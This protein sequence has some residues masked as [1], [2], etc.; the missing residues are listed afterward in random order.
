MNEVFNP[1]YRTGDRGTSIPS[2]K[3]TCSPLKLVVSNMNL[4]T[5]GVYFQG[6]A[7][8]FR[9]CN[10]SWKVFNEH[11]GEMAGYGRCFWDR[12][13]YGLPTSISGMLPMTA[14]THHAPHF[15]KS[16]GVFSLLQGKKTWWWQ[17]K[18]FLEFSLRFLGKWSNLTLR[19]FFLKWVGVPNHQLEEIVRITNGQSN[20]VSHLGPNP[21]D[22]LCSQGRQYET[23][24]PITPNWRWT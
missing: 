10:P 9:E 15:V 7:V 23:W 11:I 14:A 12:G 5:P 24:S 3:P 4:L 6:G 21:E 18:D 17:L 8:S 20:F 1:T 13:M 22:L 19:I 2:L 16:W